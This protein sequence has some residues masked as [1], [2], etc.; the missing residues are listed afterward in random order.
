MICSEKDKQDAG[1]TQR[2]P[3]TLLHV[4]QRKRDKQNKLPRNSVVALIWFYIFYTLFKLWKLLKKTSINNCKSVRIIFNH[5]TLYAG[6]CLISKFSF[7]SRIIMMGM[8]VLKISMAECTSVCYMNNCSLLNNLV[9]CE[10]NCYENTSSL[11]GICFSI[12]ED[13]K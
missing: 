10:C 9:H 6:K 3:S 8:E 4:S 5:I 13:G 11:A 7:W 2:F 12:T 1:D